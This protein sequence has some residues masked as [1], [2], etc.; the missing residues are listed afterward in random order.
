MVHFIP[1]FTVDV[2]RGRLENKISKTLVTTSVLLLLLA[3]WGSATST[4]LMD[5]MFQRTGEHQKAL[6]RFYSG[7]RGWEWLICILVW[8]LFE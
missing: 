3:V 8:V 6:G 1:S 7:F 5:I 4:H 2:E